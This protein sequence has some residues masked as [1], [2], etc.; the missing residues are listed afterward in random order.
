MAQGGGRTKIFICYRWEDT[1][2]FAGRLHA[3]L[4]ARYGRRAVFFD[5][6]SNRPGQPYPDSIAAA[7]RD[8]PV[9]VALIGRS[10]MTVKGHGGAPRIHDR[11]DIVAAEIETAIRNNLALIPVLV[12]GARRPSADELP[13][14]IRRFARY[15]CVRMGHETFREDFGRL[16]GELESAD[17][18]LQR[19]AR[20]LSLPGVRT[21]SNR[22]GS[23]GVTAIATTAVAIS[24]VLVL[25]QLGVF[26]ILPSRP[27]E[28]GED[29]PVVPVRSD[30][31]P[32]GGGPTGIA[33]SPDGQELYVANSGNNTLSVID[34]GA[35]AVVST[36]PVGASPRS[37]AVSPDG[38][39]IVVANS[40]DN[41]VSIVD[42]GDSAQKRPAARRVDVGLEPVDIEMSLR[43]DTA[44]VVE[45]TSPEGGAGTVSVVNVDELT[46]SPTVIRT[47]SPT[48]IAISPDGRTGYL[49]NPNAIALVA[50]D[51]QTLVEKSSFPLAGNDVK[52]TQDGRKI[53]LVDENAGNVSVIDALTGHLMA[54]IT[55]GLQPSSIV[56][57]RER[58]IVANSGENTLS[59]IDVSTDTVVDTVPITGI[60]PV[61]LAVSPDGGT[62][63]TAD[64]YSNTVS[65][66]QM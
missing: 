44:F 5:T 42:K 61:A 35:R 14:T 55:V 34:V 13:Q 27:Q 58:A 10:W 48:A 20:L 24:I 46:S 39:R 25:L 37:V 16:V 22:V 9:F 53:Y 8:R 66:V 4:S 21:L 40:G 54:T 29:L 56:I 63:F 33:V 57:T 49:A 52:I 23:I 1:Q 45:A 62:V 6:H 18:S 11:G 32:V 38:R 17:S 26:P 47:D 64:F 65:T 36:V 51:T 41:S 31:I 60:T 28:A 7:L 12:H 2:D 19:S 50:F 3:A 30:S 59:V 15:L 43:N